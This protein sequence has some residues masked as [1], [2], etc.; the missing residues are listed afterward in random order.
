MRLVCCAIVATM[1]SLPEDA[2]AS[3]SFD[4]ATFQV[5]T[6]W[7]RAQQEKFLRLH[8]PQQDA[9]ILLFQSRRTQTSAT[10]EFQNDWA[11]LVSAPL[12]SVPAPATQIENTPD[13]WT[14]VSGAANVNRSGANLTVM[15]ST[16]TGHGRTT[17]IVVSMVGA[18]HVA[19]VERFFANIQ[20][21]AQPIASAPAQSNA[22]SA[23]PTGNAGL[24]PL[25]PGRIVAGR[26]QGLFYDMEVGS[27]L[28]GMA[29]DRR[30]EVKVRLFLPNNR[31]ARVF[32]FGSGD[33]FDPAARCSSDTCGAYQFE[34]KYLVTRW[35][36]GQVGRVAFEAT[37]Q[38]IK[39]DG[40][41]YRPAR[42][43]NESILVGTWR[44]A[45]AIGSSMWND[46]TFASNGTFTFKSGSVGLGGRYRIQGLMLIL[47][48]DNGAERR[49]A[50]FAASDSKPINRIAVD[51]EVYTRR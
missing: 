25:G 32:P 4:I 17:S 1:I 42:A 38:E 29:T 28:G 23:A 31:I 18:D 37:A 41:R 26:P 46:Y 2:L 45:G 13:R 7:Q 6:G 9:E 21:Q 22:A 48:F 11:K 3:E 49:R 20:F 15:L 47:E 5:P 43:V 14:A 40:K 36:S 24:I 30:M 33:V 27:N 12:G 44:N 35:D 10:Q 16:V 19:A 34:K 8:S 51:N 39:L 50:L